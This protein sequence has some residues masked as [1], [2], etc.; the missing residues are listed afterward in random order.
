MNSNLSKQQT[1]TNLTL[2]G[3]VAY[4]IQFMTNLLWM[5]GWVELR[6]RIQRKWSS[7]WYSKNSTKAATC[8]SGMVIRMRSKMHHNRH[9]NQRQSPRHPCNRQLTSGTVFDA[10][11]INKLCQL[12]PI[13]RITNEPP[14]SNA[15]T[16]T[17]APPATAEAR[18]YRSH[19]GDQAAWRQLGHARSHTGKLATVKRA[20]G[21]NRITRPK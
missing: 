19:A 21:L 1:H 14:S 17:I 18:D 11:Y 12:H 13:D 20:H 3:L 15:T 4:K 16:T 2:K 10:N 6:R 9:L 8:P 5:G 7:P